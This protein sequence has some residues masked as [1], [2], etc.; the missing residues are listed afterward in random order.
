MELLFL[1]PD[2]ARRYDD[3][4]LFGGVPWCVFTRLT[5]KNDP[6]LLLSEALRTKGGQLAESFFKYSFGMADWLQTY[7]LVHINP[8]VSADGDF[9]YAVEIVYS[10]ASDAIFQ[11]AWKHSC[12]MF[13]VGVA[14]ES[15]RK[16]FEK[17]YHWLKPLDGQS[18]TITSLSDASTAEFVVPS[19]RIV[20]P[21]DWKATELCA[22][23][24]VRSSDC[25]LG[26]GRRILLRLCTFGI[27]IGGDSDY[28]GQDA[29]HQ[30]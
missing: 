24:A 25:E 7:M 12:G 27:L 8:P 13:N 19:L 11:E 18:L 20:L 30:G 5:E 14:S 6:H 9:D 26:V 23:Y 2:I 1:N 3:F 15:A 29:R 22:G 16:L 10:F 21:H 28:S 4:A 17:V